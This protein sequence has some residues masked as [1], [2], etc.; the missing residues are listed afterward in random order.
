MKAIIYV[1]NTGFTKQY[2]KILSKE[3][4]VPMYTIKEAKDKVNKKDD[5]IYLGWLMAK[6]LK[7]FKKINRKYN[8]K[9]ICGV[10]MTNDVNKQIMEIREKYRTIRQEVF[11]AQGGMDR[12]KLHGVYKI[13]I[14]KVYDV[15]KLGIEKQETISEED[16]EILDIFQNGKNCVKRENISE[17]I[18][19]VKEL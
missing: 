10:G 19:F 4:G 5:V 17:L 13:I 16:K 15:M 1:S 6:N 8:V 11:Y 14:D 7:S 12:T 3:T 18:N 9:V 2:A